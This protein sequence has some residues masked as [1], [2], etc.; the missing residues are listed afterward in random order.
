MFFHHPFSGFILP[1]SGL[2]VKQELGRVKGQQSCITAAMQSFV[3]EVFRGEVDQSEGGAGPR[4]HPLAGPGG[5]RVQE[6]RRG[7][8]RRGPLPVRQRQHRRHRRPARGH[9]RAA[10]GRAPG[11]PVPHPRPRGPH[12]PAYR[13]GH[14][15]E[16]P[17]RPDRLPALVRP[18]PDQTGRAG[19]ADPT[20]MPGQSL[21]FPNFTAHVVAAQHTEDSVG[22][23]FEFS[24]RG[25]RDRQHRR[26]HHRRHGIQRRRWRPRSRSSGRT[27]CWCRSTGAGATW[28]PPRRR[29]WRRRSRR[30]R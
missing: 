22:F 9:P 13:A 24:E 17:R 5:V 30:A 1:E 7:R 3:W 26:L 15:A 21:E 12:R 10:Q 2:R 29:S 6:P 8:H 27:C 19:D 20:A 18:S 28:T 16:Q 23:V 14:R 25:Q 4:R 11:L